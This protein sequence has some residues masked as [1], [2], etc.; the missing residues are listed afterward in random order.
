MTSVVTDQ[1]SRR[2]PLEDI[3]TFLKYLKVSNDDEEFIESICSKLL[4][5][6]EDDNLINNGVL[7]TELFQIL[8]SV[9]FFHGMELTEKEAVSVM[10]AQ[11]LLDIILQ[12][13]V[14]GQAA[15]KKK[16]RPKIAKLVSDCNDIAN[17]KGP[18]K[19]K[20]FYENTMMVIYKF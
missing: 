7:F 5:L 20:K 1:L 15:S 11:T 2:M 4:I 6:H 13:E 17:D 9:D 14:F 19:D 8:V 16:M 3:P 12:A 10:C 18:F